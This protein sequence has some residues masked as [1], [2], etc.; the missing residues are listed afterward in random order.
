MAKKQI[1]CDKCKGTGKVAA[2]DPVRELEKE[3]RELKRRLKEVEN[4]P[5]IVI[6]YMPP[7]TFPPGPIVERPWKITWR[8]GCGPYNHGS[9]GTLY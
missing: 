4:H 2:P 3:V 8:D 6:P 7:P 9:G 5:P 1:E